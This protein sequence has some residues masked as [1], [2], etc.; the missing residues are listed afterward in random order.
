[1]ARW[2]ERLHSLLRLEFQGLHTHA[3][4]RRIVND[5]QPAQSD[6]LVRHLLT[7]QSAGEVQF[8]G[9]RW[10][11]PVLQ[12][13]STDQFDQRLQ[14]TIVDH[15]K[16]ESLSRFLQAI[17]AQVLPGASSSHDAQELTFRGGQPESG[18]NLFAKLLPHYAECLRLGGATRLGAFVDRHKTQFHLLD[19]R[20]RWW[21]DAAGARCLR[22]SRDHLGGPF[23]QAL[24]RR[25]NDPILLGYPISVARLPDDTALIHPVTLLQCRWQV[26]DTA[27]TL[28]PMG[29][30]P[31][32]N[33]DWTRKRANRRDFKSTLKRLSELASP[34]DEDLSTTVRDFWRDVP[35]MAGTL[36]TFLP[37]SISGS[38][39]P[40]GLR[41]RLDLTE[42]DMIQNVLGLFLI[43]ENTYT[44]GSRSDLMTLRTIGESD[45]SKTALAPFFGFER[46]AGDVLPVVSPLPVG[47]DQFVA[48]RDGLRHPLTVISGPPGTGKSQVVAALMISA[49]MAGRSV[50]FSSHTH[51]AIDAVQ[52]RLIELSPDRPLLV[53]AGSDDGAGSID[54]RSAID[55]LIARLADTP[56]REALA[57]DL[58]DVLS[59][60]RQA[61]ALVDQAD[62]L[63]RCS[64]QLARLWVERDRRLHAASPE[65]PINRSRFRFWNWRIIA[66]LAAWLSA[67]GAAL[68][69]SVEVGQSQKTESALS[70][71]GLENAIQEAE[72]S[73][74]NMI[75]AFDA[76]KAELP[77]PDLLQKLVK[78]STAALPSLTSALDAANASERERLTTLLGNVGL[79]TS[80]IERLAVWRDNTDLVMR[81]F[82]LWTATALSVPNRIPLVPAMFD[83]VIIDEATTCN[84]AQALPLL[85]RARSAIIVGDKMQT[86]MI[87][88]L[89]AM[90]EREM[91]TRA[92]LRHQAIGRYAF[93]Q[94]SL[95]DLATSIPAARRHLLRDHFRCAPE[96]AGFVSE[97]FYGSQLF[98]RT[99]PNGLKAPPNFR[100]GMHWTNIIG[101]IEAA[102]NGCR[103]PA[104]AQAIADHIHS[105]LERQNYAGTVGVVTP[106]SRQAELIRRLI[107]QRVSFQ[108]IEASRLVV[109]TS[110]AFQGD[111]RDLI[112]VSLCYGPGMPRGSEW[113]LSKSRDWLN[114]AVSRARAV[115]HIFGDREAAERSAIQ[116]IK[117]LSRWLTVSNE[118]AQPGDPV[119]ESPWERRLYEALIEKGVTPITQYPLAGRRLDLAVVTD[120]VRLDI[121]V[122]GDRYHRDRDGFRRVSDHWRD[123][124]IQTL[125]WRVRRFWVYE[126]K[127]DMEACVE[128]VI[129]D[130]DTHK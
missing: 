52:Q 26:D 84:I 90:R 96:I 99:D 23:L 103:A 94:V 111:D 68:R 36:T 102:G 89:D 59:I 71:A 78:L 48:V 27:L 98:V 121:E 77:L 128:R 47:E 64:D 8:V 6:Q 57:M 55:A 92:G 67:V 29:A 125:G 74:R 87:S 37:A 24:S 3:L 119:F 75:N 54:F 49:A 9:R 72:V 122:D 129:R 44:E 2:P 101:P 107:E 65:Q 19:V 123:H 88:D 25:A 116:H 40:G 82:P 14:F 53:R 73:H 45:L 32:L 115:C 31:I 28:W 21:P 62:E 33:P 63:T 93:S 70:D 12:P 109:G 124:V 106:F 60:E 76:A 5:G 80:K 18:W 17:P 127:E 42:T 118:D 97:T 58:I 95:F 126:L 41:P 117:R 1:M 110:H 112:M 43:S 105:L 7:S 120:G 22:V 113:F 10:A 51:K 81:H 39:D 35:E 34:T 11:I 114:V 56:A 83:Y 46:E 108:K 30:A 79:A 20:A 104:E 91:L 86:G 50:L 38:L 85:A 4:R 130:L 69:L 16:N 61:S 66:A 15:K 100:N 13:H